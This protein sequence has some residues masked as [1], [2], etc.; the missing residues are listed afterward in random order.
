LLKYFGSDLLHVRDVGW[1]A[2]A[3]THWR[4]EGGLEIAT[5]CAQMT[6]ARIV[7]EADVMA[8]T[9]I[10]QHMIEAGA[11]AREA[12]AA[13][14]KIKDQSDGQKAKR[15]QL[16]ATIEAGDAAA[17]QLK[18]RQIARRKYSVSSGNAGKIKGMI[19]Q[20]LP[21]RTV[22]VDDLDDDMLAFNVMNGTLRFV[23]DD[24]PDPGA[25]AHST[26]TI[27]QYRAELSLHDRA[28]HITKVAPVEYDPA[29]KCPTFDAS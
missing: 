3:N 21:H 9:P 24:V 13:L 10:E 28:D 2:W 17:G 26:K 8:A 22:T 29:A 16:L 12:L 4:R 20:A 25:P 1:H 19:D 6:A 15:K 11:K 5:R 14:D 23:Y 7:L 27:K 18:A